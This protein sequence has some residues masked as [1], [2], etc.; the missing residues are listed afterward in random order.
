MGGDKFGKKSSKKGYTNIFSAS[1]L[2]IWK[3]IKFN[4][5][6]LSQFH[7]FARFEMIEGF[8][9]HSELAFLLVSPLL[10]RTI[11]INK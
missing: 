1:C 4:G 10:S 7:S 6:L 8:F 2:Y 3:F 5:N 9:L 11:V